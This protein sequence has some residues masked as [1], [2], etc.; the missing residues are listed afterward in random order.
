M[1]SFGMFA[2]ISPVVVVAALRST[3]SPC[4]L[5][6]ASTITRIGESGRGRSF[7]PTALSYSIGAVVGGAG[8]GVLGTALSQSLRWMGLS[9]SSGLA[10]SGAL[11]LLAALA[12]IGAIG[13]ALP[14]IRRQVDERWIDEYRGWVLGFGYGC[15]IGFGLC[16]YVMTTGVYLVVALGAVLLQ[17]PQAL[18]IG[19]VF[20]LV[21]GAVVWL[22]ATIS[23][24]ADLDHM[25]AR[26]AALEP[27]SRR[28]APASYIVAGLGCSG[29]GFGARPEIVAG[30][31]AVAAV[32]GVV[33]AGLTVS[34]ARRTE[35]LAF[36]TQ[37]LA[38]KTEGLAQQ[39][40]GRAPRTSSQGASR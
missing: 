5:S 40:Q 22:G 6:V 1:T 39:S 28:I 34:R 16:T 10:L 33:V 14:H 36:R 4:G 23:S 30:V 37:D 27:V 32:G 21:R 20:G 26:F 8:L 31:S 9:E 12:D 3:W 13:P 15:Q 35:V 25:H 24:P 7:A 38:L 19:L 18:L 29:L 11:L 2:A 17:P